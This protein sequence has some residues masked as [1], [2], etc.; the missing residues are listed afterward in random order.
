VKRRLELLYPGKYKLDI[1]DQGDCFLVNLTLQV[2]DKI[3]IPNSVEK[4][5]NLTETKVIENIK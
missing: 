4:T 2:I 3:S 1:V 5:S